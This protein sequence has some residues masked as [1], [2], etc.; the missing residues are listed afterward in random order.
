MSSAL[1]RADR[2]RINVEGSP[3]RGVPHQLLHDFEFNSE[4]SEQ[5]S[6]GAPKGVPS[7]LLMDAQPL[8]RWLN[9]LSKN[10]WSPVELLSIAQ[11]ACECPI[12]FS[13]EFA[14]GP[15]G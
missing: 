8:G 15:P 12:I 2:L 3:Q 9:V 4:A 13:L 7:D 11:P 1:G 5:S 6:V 14:M 10:H